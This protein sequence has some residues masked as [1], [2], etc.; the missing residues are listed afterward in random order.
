LLIVVISIYTNALFIFVAVSG[1]LGL[2][3]L[4]KKDLIVGWVKIKSEHT[5]LQSRNLPTIIEIKL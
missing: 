2:P 3:N 1:R 4:G 5:A